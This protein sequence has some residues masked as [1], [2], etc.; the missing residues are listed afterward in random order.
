[1]AEVSKIQVMRSMETAVQWRYFGSG[2][3]RRFRHNP[4]RLLH[5]EMMGLL[6][7]KCD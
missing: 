6:P 4:R 7:Q 3:A 5:R 2:R 1:M